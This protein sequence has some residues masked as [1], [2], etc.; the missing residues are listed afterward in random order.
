MMVQKQVREHAPDFWEYDNPW[1]KPEHEVRWVAHKEGGMHKTYISYYAPT[2]YKGYQIFERIKHVDKSACVCDVVL[3][4]K[5][6]TQRVT[7][8]SCMKYIDNIEV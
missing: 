4:G 5:V 8:A 7:V 6:L 1:F 3:D 2:V